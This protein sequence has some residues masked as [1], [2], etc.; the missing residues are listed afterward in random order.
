MPCETKKIA[1]LQVKSC[2]LL[3]NIGYFLHLCTLI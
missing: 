3:G 1:M 2:D